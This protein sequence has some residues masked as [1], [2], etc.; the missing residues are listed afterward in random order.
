[1]RLRLT[2]VLAGVA[3]TGALATLAL[4]G[5]VHAA[6]AQQAVQFQSSP[7]H[8]FADPG[9][10]SVSP[11]TAIGPPTQ[12]NPNIGGTR[13][14]ENGPQ[15]GG[16]C[17][18]YTG[19]GDRFIDGASDQ[20][21]G[22]GFYCIVGNLVSSIATSGSSGNGYLTCADNT[23]SSFVAGRDNQSVTSDCNDNTYSLHLNG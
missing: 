20:M 15:N 4:P 2:S 12:C 22:C 11:L 6:P 7:H 3:L 16:S 19:N 8:S 9:P 23:T 10:P 18:R 14:W 1:M 21:Q 17:A 5:A 13:L